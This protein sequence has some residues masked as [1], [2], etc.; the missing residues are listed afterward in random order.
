MIE[1]PPEGEWAIQQLDRTDEADDPTMAWA[2]REPYRSR[3]QELL[4]LDPRSVMAFAALRRRGLLDF[5]R[6]SKRERGKYPRKPH[7]LDYAADDARRISELFRRKRKKPSAGLT[8]ELIAAERHIRITNPNRCSVG[9]FVDLEKNVDAL[10]E[11]EESALSELHELA[12][13]VHSRRH[14]RSGS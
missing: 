5:F 12:E 10:T 4:G 8:A 7:P 13:R 6:P 14:H 9:K 3:L 1:L 2:V 11:Q